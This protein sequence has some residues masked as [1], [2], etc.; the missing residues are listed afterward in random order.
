MKKK[1]AMNHVA[2]KIFYMPL[3]L[4][5]YLVSNLTLT[6]K[7]IFARL[8]N[9]FP[10]YL[11]TWNE[12]RNQ[13]NRMFRIPLVYKVQSAHIE[14]TNVC[15][16]KCK[17][18][19]PQNLKGSRRG[20]MD[21]SLF[22]KIIDQLTDLKVA[23]LSWNGESFLHPKFFEM[24]RYAK[25]RG[26]YVIIY[27]NGTCLTPENIEKVFA[28]GVAELDVSVD[29]INDV[30]ENNRGFDYHILKNN[31]L[32]LLEARKR[33]G[34]PITIL[35]T[36]TNL[37]NDESCREQLVAEWGDKVDYIH[38]AHLMG[39]KIKLRN[40][41]CKTIFR[42]AAISWDGK[43]CPCVNDMQQS[44]LF[45]EI[46]GNKKIIDIIN[47]TQAQEYRLR[48]IKKQFEGVCKYC[49]EFYG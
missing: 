28:S 11:S 35:L 22:K 33:L 3:W 13:L 16:L 6:D 40:K 10:T 30:Y 1:A 44:M 47:S 36:A 15:N 31:L 23:V 5:H 34:Y 19:T 4:I 29:G 9:Y 8:R 49:D 27:T 25:D 24:C 14:L 41:T 2:K 20:M 37:P 18:C 7:R 12:F 42:H 39:E 38:F 21:F 26:I 45:D 48:H 43:V 46:D 32:N 17:H